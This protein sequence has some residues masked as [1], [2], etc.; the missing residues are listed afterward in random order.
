[1]NRPMVILADDL[2]G[3]ADGGAVCARLGLSVF[4]AMDPDRI[5]TT[6][7]VVS[8]D[9]HTRSMRPIAA[10]AEIRRLVAQTPGDRIL[11][12]K[13]DSTLRGHVGV[14]LAAALDTWR[15][16]KGKAAIA[17]FSPAFPATGRTLVG[18]RPYLHGVPLEQTALWRQEG[19]GSELSLHC[20]MAATG[21]SPAFIYLDTVRSPSLSATML[22]LRRT[23]DI[24][25]CDAETDAD[26]AAIAQASLA[27]GDET[28]WAGSAGL[29]GHVAG[30]AAMMSALTREDRRP[31]A[32]GPLLFVVGSMA[33]VCQQQV[34]KVLA[35]TGMLRLSIPL[36][37]LVEGAEALR[38]QG[39]PERLRQHLI[40][41]RDVLVLP[42]SDLPADP[43]QARALLNGLAF[44]AGPF[45]SHLGGLFVTGGETGH[46]VLAALGVD[47]LHLH[48]ELEPGVP[49]SI[50]SGPH[51]F[52]VVT[53]AGAFGDAQTMLNSHQALRELARM[54]AFPP[55]THE[56][57][58]SS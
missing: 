25:I 7:N 9:A 6:A 23:A 47:G 15:N 54:A 4:V 48:R 49:L 43:T 30:A 1:M 31:V 27:L 21:L 14:E 12:K 53:K 26:L 20:M 18:G 33:P 39:W 55:S 13:V 45:A 36:A 57:E 29:A 50:A 52:G 8:V 11:F 40:A 37:A 56:A 16:V 17:V 46:A 44:L 32:T 28:V 35:G 2:T 34:E 42:R 41:G 24:L 38:R 22:T 51:R 58:L 3:A 5:G 10:A 19:L